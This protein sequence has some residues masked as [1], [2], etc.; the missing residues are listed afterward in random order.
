VPFS[1]DQLKA[2]P[3]YSINELTGNDGQKARDASYEYFKVE[4]Y[5]Y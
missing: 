2:A 1:K 4:P 3:A 5:W